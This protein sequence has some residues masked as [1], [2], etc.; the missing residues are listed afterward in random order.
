VSNKR[1]IKMQNVSWALIGISIM[2]L[3][4]GFKV[5][6]INEKLKKL[7]GEN[8]KDSNNVHNAQN[9]I[10]NPPSSGLHNILNKKYHNEGG[11]SK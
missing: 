11:D 9:K 8:P 7:L 5:I 4:I 1:R 10:I 6:D 3:F 2:L